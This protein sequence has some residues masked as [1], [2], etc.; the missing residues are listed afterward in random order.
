MTQPFYLTPAELRE[1]EVRHIGRRVGIWIAGNPRVTDR[2]LR[3]RANVEPPRGT[4]RCIFCGT[5]QGLMVGH[6][7]GHEENNEPR[8]K[9][10][11]CRSCN[12]K[13]G[14]AFKRAGVGRRTR[15]YNPQGGAQS[16]GAWMNAVMSM[17]GES[18]GDMTI[19]DAVAMIKATS[20]AKR[21]DFAHQIWGMRYRRGTAR[22]PEVP[23]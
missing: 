23:F 12:S 2:A 6:I 11:T 8:N 10:W 1:A 21:S 16:L 13:T 14:H 9:A 7:D 20:A 15:Q 4:K 17:K 19:P 5:T 18:G 3:Y 22:K